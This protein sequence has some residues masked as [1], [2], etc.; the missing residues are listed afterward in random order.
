MK[1]AALGFRVS[2]LLLT[3]GLGACGPS[4]ADLD[5]VQKQLRE[6]SAERD[7]LKTQHDQDQTKMAALQQQVTN[8]EQAAAAK[9]EE[10]AKTASKA[11]GKKH[12]R[13]K[14]RRKRR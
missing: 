9:S 1:R 4:Q 8:L 7:S 12:A 2:L 5:R 3:F 11:A 13:T 10:Q 6:V 14:A